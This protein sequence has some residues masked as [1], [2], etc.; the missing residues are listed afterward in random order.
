[1]RRAALLFQVFLAGRAY[2][3]DHVRAMRLM[4]EAPEAMDY[5]VATGATHRLEDFLVT[6]FAAAAGATGTK[7]RASVPGRFP[8]GVIQGRPTF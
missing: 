2:A 6:A 8:P 4:V 1:M 5:V 7:T 3:L